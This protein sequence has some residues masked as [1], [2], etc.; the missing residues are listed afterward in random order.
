MFLALVFTV[1]DSHCKYVWE[2]FF[3]HLILLRDNLYP[4]RCTEVDSSMS[5]DKCIHPC[6]PYIHVE[7]IELYIEQY[8][9]HFHHPWDFPQAPSQSIPA[10]HPHPCPLESVTVPMSCQKLVLPNLKLHLNEDI[11]C[12]VFCICWFIYFFKFRIMLLSFNYVVV[13]ISSL[14]LLIA[15]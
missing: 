15:E 1:I 2:P 9:E 7:H 11:Q 10:T 3:F 13:C 6:N 8:T 5:F 12:V 14:F 4:V